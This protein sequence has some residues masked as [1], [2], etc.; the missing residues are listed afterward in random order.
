[1]SLAKVSEWKIIMLYIG[2]CVY[3]DLSARFSRYFLFKYLLRCFYSTFKV[4]EYK[5]Y[6]TSN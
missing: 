4:N 5:Q 3:D 2:L 6:S 1:L